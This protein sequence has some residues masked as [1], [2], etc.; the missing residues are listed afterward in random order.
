MYK[1]TKYVLFSDGKICN[2]I[3]TL[4]INTHNIQDEKT[5]TSLGIYL[6]NLL[7]WEAHTKYIEK[8][9]SC[10][11]YALN[12]VKHL[13]SSVHL[14]SIYYSL[15]H[16]HLTYGCTLWGNTLKKYLNKIKVNQKKA[17]R[18]VCH[19]KYNAHTQ[20]LFDEKNIPAFEILYKLQTCQL[21]FKLYTQMLP[22]PLLDILY[23]NCDFHGYSTRHSNDFKIQKHKS[24][25]VAQSFLSTGP[26]LWHGLPNSIKSK[27]YKLYCKQITSYFRANER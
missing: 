2:H 18:I 25:T 7:I 27:N 21:M 15:I 6:D 17:I 3:L 10:G 19:R 16:S 26:K 23:R 1:Q 4:Q 5:I 20:P 24:N 8:K 9:T 11:L 12:S 22:L 13:L 14:T